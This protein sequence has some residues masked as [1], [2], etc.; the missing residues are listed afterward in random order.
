M[1]KR[2]RKYFTPEQRRKTV[3]EFLESGMTAK[4][5]SAKKNLAAVTLS[6]WARDYGHS[7]SQRKH[8][9]SPEQRRHAIT[10][11]MRSGLTQKDFARVWGVD[12]KTL[13]TWI[14][15]YRIDGPKGLENGGIYGSNKKRGRKGVKEVVKE[16]VLET[17][18][19]LPDF[20]LKKMQQFLY[21][22]EGVKISP[23]TIKKI[24]KENEQ[25]EPKVVVKKKKAPPQIRRFERARPMQLWQTDITSFVLPRS[26]QRV[27]LVVF[28][29]DNSRYIVS[30]SLAL[31]QTGAFVMECMING[32]E[33]FGK[34]EE[35]L[36][37]QGRQ[38]FSWRGKSEFQKLLHNEGVEHV[39]SRSHHPQTLGKCERF[40]KTV[41]KEFWDRLSPR[42]LDEAKERFHH[43]VNHYNHFRP[44]QGI[45]G[46]TPADRFFDVESEVKESIEKTLTQNELRLAL[47][48]SP[49]KPFF[50][51]GQVGEQKI[52]MHGEKGKLVVQTPEGSVEGLD[53]E[54]F[55]KQNSGRN[56]R[57]EGQY[58]KAI[59]T[60][61]KNE[62]KSYEACNTDQ[63]AMG[64]SERGAE[65]AGPKTSYS[66]D[67]IL[68]RTY[69]ED[70]S[71]SE[72]GR[73]SIENLADESISSVGN[74]CGP[75]ETTE[76]EENYDI[77][78][79]RS[80]VFEEEDQGIGIYDRDAGSL[81]SNLEIDAGVSRDWY[82]GEE[83]IQEEDFEES[84]EE[85][86]KTWQEAKGTA[87]ISNLKSDYG[88]WKRD[89][90]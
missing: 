23:N 26:K 2:K 20:G 68:D 73:E 81:D 52:S 72:T 48:K 89:E 49:R 79:R 87:R 13:S 59:E 53:Y 61:N 45:D 11:F 78:R 27:Y 74:V 3:E 29:D 39:V 38:Y 56:I 63:G 65:I 10:E 9:Y 76:D 22:F 35:V 5:F 18:K 14:R 36:S 51:V 4:D 70:A 50:F 33:K 31:K 84:C 77:E 64:A 40:W 17:S 67:R 1:A 71:S 44:H 8:H 25:F 32:F 7:Y 34:P 83:K 60:K 90:E 37:D 42:T 28:L 69:N 6:R 16:R 88:Y 24:L 85:G 80:E 82:R 43:F 75:F 46:M 15:N 86:S 55:G 57:E 66:S 19:R 58:N 12:T 54:E 47:D 30:W 62:C 41:G 21:R